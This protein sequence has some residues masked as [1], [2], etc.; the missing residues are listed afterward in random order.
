MNSA[1][2]SSCAPRAPGESRKTGSSTDPATEV[3][4][5]PIKAFGRFR[6]VDG[7]RSCMAG[8]TTAVPAPKVADGNA[9]EEKPDCSAVLFH[10]DSTICTQNHLYQSR[11]V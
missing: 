9:C 2:R 10:S 1:R 11:V 4:F 3:G 5:E 6:D 8:S 7:A